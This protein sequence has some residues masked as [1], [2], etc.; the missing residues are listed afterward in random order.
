V[1][2]DTCDGSGSCTD[3]G[4]KGAGTACG[5]SAA[6]ECTNPDTCNGSG[7]CLANDKPAGTNCG[8]A[9]TEC[10]NQDTCDG[11]GSCTDNGFKAAGTGC[12]DPSW[13]D[14]DNPDSC[15]GSGVCLANYKAAGTACTD[16][17]NVCTDDL[18]NGAGSCVH[19]NNTVPCNDGNACTQT[20]VCSG[21][22]CVGTNYSWSGV[23][24]PINPDGSSIFKFG[25]TIPVK[26]K[27]TG[28][29]AR[30]P[31]LVAH[32]LIAKM[33]NSIVGTYVEA[34]STSAADTGNTFRYSSTDD[35]YIYNLATKPLSAGAWQIAIDLGDGSG[36]RLAPLISLKP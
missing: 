8:D 25:S 24:Q 2:Q 12:G 30:S 18:C 32:I 34:T 1:N 19:P 29:C 17:G 35:Q 27:L 21:G 7:V 13:S 16:D 3:N 9:G 15:N 33:S 14:C 26:F 4:F 20:D 6:T 22:R 36:N 23:L 10:V 28:A 31:S 5:S 11:S